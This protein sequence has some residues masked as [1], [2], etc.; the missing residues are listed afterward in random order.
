LSDDVSVIDT[1][2]DEEVG[3]IKVGKFPNGIST[4]TKN[5]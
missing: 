5:K 4:W 2:K 1:A 3:R